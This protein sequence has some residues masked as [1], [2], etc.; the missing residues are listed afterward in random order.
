MRPWAN[1][2]GDDPADRPESGKR[3]ALR[4]TVRGIGRHYLFVKQE[5]AWVIF[6]L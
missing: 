2:N 6:P 3:L 5:G 4:L 1:Q